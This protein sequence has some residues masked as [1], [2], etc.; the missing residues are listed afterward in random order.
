M[1]HKI[2]F[3]MAAVLGLAGILYGCAEDIDNMDWEKMGPPAAATGA[4][5]IGYMATEGMNETTRLEV[6]G[7]AAAGG[8]IIAEILR[9]QAEEERREFF[10]NGYILGTAHAKARQSGIEERIAAWKNP[11]STVTRYYTFPGIAADRNGSNTTIPYD[12]VLPVD[13]IR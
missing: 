2:T 12:A 9:R 1:M 7:A 13:D 4:G 3:K 5:A 6:A 10:R 11:A 8:F